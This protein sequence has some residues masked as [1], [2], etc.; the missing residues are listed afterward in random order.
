[1]LLRSCPTCPACPACPVYA[2]HAAFRVKGRVVTER[3]E[4]IDKADVRLEAF[5]GYAAGTFCRRAQV[6]GADQHARASGASARMQ[7]GVW[8]F[9]VIAPGYLPETV[10]L[11]IRILT[12]VSMGTSGMALPWDL[13]LKPVPPPDDAQGE[14]LKQAAAAARDG[15]VDEV[16]AGAAGHARRIRT[17]TSSPAPAA[18]RWWRATWRWRRTL[19]MR[20]LE[21]DPSSYR[22]ALGIASMFMLERDFDSA[23]RA[24]D[25]ARSRTHDKDEQKFLTVAIGDLATIKI[26]MRY[27]LSAAISHQP[28][29]M[30]TQTLPSA[31]FQRA[32]QIL[33]GGV[34][35]PV[36]AF[37]SG[38]RARR[39]SSAA[40]RGARIE[41]VDGN[42]LHR[43]RDV[44]GAAHPRPRAARPRQGAR[45]RG[46][47]TAPASARRARSRSSSASASAR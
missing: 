32:Q 2:Q 45:R 8:L 14:L 33:P 40:R 28:S 24:F 4:P 21:R 47:A 11:P 44:V 31:S 37:K 17:P 25:A 38:R 5:Y 9:E 12:T 19:F 10:V 22:A 43:L 13:I 27:Q 23:S 39:S 41:D 35:S 26:V 1:M 30:T 3:G 29:A 46:E 7:P 42:T 6:L 34:D 20:A 16:R 15:K 36:R 18:S